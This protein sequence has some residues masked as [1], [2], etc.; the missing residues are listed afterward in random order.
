MTATP[1]IDAATVA[2]LLDYPTLVDRLRAAFI[3][4]P[5]TPSRLSI[6]I[7]TAVGVAA[8]TLLVMPALRPGGLIIVKLVAAHPHLGHR[9]QGTLTTTLLV[10]SALDGS[11]L[12]LVDGHA[13]TARRTAAT[14]VLATN[15]LARPD[16]RRLLVLGA[17][18]VAFALAQAY[19]AC[20]EIDDVTIWARRPAAAEVLVER[21]R[22]AGV[23]ARA[24][25]DL[26]EAAAAA[27]II[28][29][30]TASSVPLLKKSMISPGTHIDLVG[31]F[32]PVMREAEDC[33]VAAARVVADGPLAV[34]EAGDLAGP[35]ALGILDPST[36]TTLAS[37][38]AAPVAR[39]TGELTLFKS[40][41]LALEDL[42][43]A[44]LLFE[45]LETP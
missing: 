42:A 12:G 13:L 26:A 1:Y 15:L 8:G 45:R 34:S 2:R 27:D 3:S 32:T 31:G 14:S 43:A 30:A 36:I 35:V 9:P 23:A 10:L 20:R 4:P 29:T 39:A 18:N 7:P 22:S 17:G 37:L 11:L 21:L 28:S 6:S 41:G 16:A 38:I 33:L 44:E 24:A 40:V 19:V 25:S 5:I